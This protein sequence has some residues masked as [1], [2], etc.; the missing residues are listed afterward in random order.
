V[1]G[2]PDAPGFPKGFLF[3]LIAGEDFEDRG[4]TDARRSRLRREQCKQRGE[5]AS[6]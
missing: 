2:C 4:N 5:N 1:Y 6:R 3:S